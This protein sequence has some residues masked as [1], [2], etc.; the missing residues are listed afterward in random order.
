MLAVLMLSFVFIVGSIAAVANAA[1]LPPDGAAIMQPLGPSASGA[2]RIS[3]VYG[4][5]GNSG[6]TYKRDFIEL[7]NVGTTSVDVTGW[8]VQ[9]ASAASG[10]WTSTALTGTIAPGQY[11]LVAERYGAGGSVDLT[12]DISGSI[13]MATTD[14]KVA[15]ANNGVTLSGTCPSSAN[16]QDFIGYGG[17]VTCTETSPAPAPSNTNADIR[18][19]NGCQD[20]DNNSLDF[21][22]LTA[23][24]RNTSSPINI[25]GLSISKSAVASIPVNKIFTYTLV[26][27]NATITATDV[28][29]TDLIPSNATYLPNSA[30]SAG[31]LI[32]GTTISWTI[33]SIVHASIVSRTFVVTAPLASGEVVNDQYRVSASNI[34]SAAIGSAITTSVLPASPHLTFSKSVT[35]NLNVANNSA[36]TYT[37]ILTNDEAA[38]ANGVLM[39]DT[40]PGALTFAD[41]IISP[42]NTAVS[43]QLITWTGTISAYSVIS[44]NFSAIVSGTGQTV[45]NSA[46]IDYQSN[47]TSASASLT[48]QPAANVLINELDAQ[49]TGTDAA[50]FVELYD[51]G[52][53]QTG[54]DGLVLVFF[55]GNAANDPSYYSIDLDNQQTD[56]NGYFVVGNSAIASAVITF[57]DGKLQN[58]FDAVG[59]FS[60]N[61]SDFSSTPATSTSLIDAIVYSDYPT[62][63]DDAVLRATLLN[64]NEPIVYE[65]NTLALADIRSAQRCPNSSGGFRNT[66]AYQSSAPTAGTAN[67]CPAL[68]IAKDVTPTNNVAYH[69]NV[70]YTLV[71]SNSGAGDAFSTQLTDTLPGEVDFG[72]WIDRFGA[73][74]NSDVITWTGEVTAH[75]SIAFTFSVTHVGSYSDVVTNTAQFAHNTDSGS[76]SSTFSVVPPSPRLS[77]SKNA[78]PNS[79]VSVHGHVTYTLII[80]NDGSADALNTFITDTLPS[81][82]AFDHWID[83]SSAVI[84]ADRITWNG[85]ISIGQ[86]I[87]FTFVVSHVGTYGDVVTNTAQFDQAAGSGSSDAVFNVVSATPNLALTKF[88]SPS[89]NVAYHGNVT[90]TLLI[91]NSGA[92]DASQTFITDALPSGVTF[93]RWI[94]QAGANESANVITWNGTVTAANTLQFSFVV[95]HTGAYGESITNTAQFA[96]SSGAGSSDAAFSIEPLYPIVFVYHDGEDVV[97]SGEPVSISIDFNGMTALTADVGYTLFSNTINLPAGAHSYRYVAIDQPDWLNTLTR[98]ITV[99]NAATIDDYRNVIVDAAKLQAPS[100]TTTTIGV[101]TE[102]IFGRLHILN[103]TE[104]TGAGR[105]LKAQLGYGPDTS[106]SNWIWSSINFASQAGNDDQFASTITPNATGLYSVAVRFDPNWG[107]DNPNAGWTYGDLNDLPFTIDQAGVLH[108][109]NGP[110]LSI[111]KQVTP[112]LRVPRGGVVTY[113][114]VL[115]NNGDLIANSVSFTDALPAPADF[116]AWIISPTN[117]IQASDIITWSGDIQS[118]QTITFA[119]TSIVTGAY[120]ASVTNTASIAYNNSLT[121]GSAAFTF[122]AASIIINEIDSDNVSTDKAEFIEL[123][124][125]GV[126]NTSL[127]GLVVVLFS[128]TGSKVSAPTFDLDSYSTNSNGYFLIGGN[129]ISLTADLSFT[130]PS[131]LLNVPSAVALFVGSASDFPANKTIT[132]TD[133]SLVMDAIVYNNSNGTATGLLPLLNAGQSQVNENG[134][135]NG[136][137]QSLQRCLNGSGGLRNTSTVYPS[138]PT[139]G[140]A[141]ACPSLS[142]SKSVTP[143]NQVAYHGNVTTTLLLSNSGAGDALTAQLTDTLPAE[144]DFARWITRSG[145]NAAGDVIT[146]TGEVTASQSITFTFVVTHVGTFND[147]V[148]NTGQFTHSTGSGS[149]NATFTVAPP[150]PHLSLIKRVSPTSNVNYRGNVTYTIVLSNDGSA[151]A[152]NTFLTDT[153][154]SEVDFAQWLNQSGANVASDVITWTGTIS[155]GQAITFTFVVT[156]VGNYG[157]VVTNTA[158]FDQANGSGSGG[159]TFN[160]GVPALHMSKQANPNTNVAYHGNVT[161]T[162]VLSNDGSAAAFDTFLTDTLPSEVDFAHWISQAGA[163]LNADQITWHGTLSAGQSITFTFVVTHVGDYGDVV[164]NT[165][166]FTHNTGSGSSSA[167]FSVLTATPNLQLSKSVSPNNGV[168]YHGEVTYTISITNSGAA[169]AA[170]TFITDAL[171]SGVTFARWINQATATETANVIAW[172][173]AVSSA[174]S[175]ALTFVVT[176]TGSYG[177]VITNVAQF[178]HSSGAGSASAT[179]SVV[180]AT[181][182]LVFSKNVTPNSNVANQSTVTYTLVLMNDGSAMAN[183]VLLTDSLPSALTFGGWIVS[184]TN[185][186]LSGQLIT[187]SGNIAAGNVISWNFTAI[188]SGTGLTVNNIAQ[189]NHQ[190][191]VTSASASLTVQPSVNILINEIDADTP[192]TDAAEFIELYDGGVGHTALDGLVLVL[193]NGSGNDVYLPTFDLDGYATDANGYFVIGNAAITSAA[194]VFADNKL[195]NGPEAAALFVGSASDFPAGKTITATDLSQ[196]ID[197]IVYRN[198]S[199]TAPNLQVLLNANEPQPNENGRSNAANQSLQ[200]CPNGSGGY[201][202]TVTYYPSVPTAGAANA[203]PSLSISKSVN[204]TSNVAY[205][206]NVTYTIVVSNNGSADA[207]NT[208]VTDTLPSQVDFAHWI[209]Q[210]SATVNADKIT[211]N[212]TLSIGQAITLT[213]VV[214]HVGSYGDVVTNTAQFDHASGSGSSN[215]IF[216]VLTATPNLQLTKSASPGSNVAY[217]GEVTYTVLITNSGALD[218]VSIFITDVLPSGVTFA[219]WLD[220]AGAN[221]N[222]NVITWTGT[223]SSAQSI[224]LMFVVTHTGLYGD[225]ITNTAQFDHSSGTGSA[226]ATFTVVQAAPHLVFS[227]NVNPNSNVANH[228][229][230]TY[231]LMLTNDGSA[232]ANGVL[233]TDSLPSA[234]TFGSWIVSPTNTA[235]NGQALIWSGNVLTG[236]VLVWNFTAV[237]SGTGLTVNNLAQINYQSI[238]TAASASLVVLPSVNVLINELDGQQAG[239]PDLAEFIELYDGGTGHTPLDGLALVFFNGGVTNDPAY[240]AIDLD[241]QQTDANGYFVVGNAAIASATI[242]FADGKLQNGPDAVGLYVGNASDF[243]STPATNT[244][245]IDAIVYSD[246]ASTGDDAVLRSTL[247][248]V[249]QPL[250]VEGSNASQADIRSAQRCL[251][252]SGGYRNT[253][254]YQSSVPTPGRVNAC[255]SLSIT[256]RVTPTNNVAYHG[257][258]TYTLVLSNSGAGDALTAQLTDTLPGETDFAKWITRSGA[259]AA[260]DVITWT[261]LVTANQSITFT[262]VVTY[263]GA[264]GDVVTN[265]AQFAHD[266]GSGSSVATFRVIP[267]T[268]NL[269]IHKSVSPANNVAY[270][271]PVT[272]TLVLSNNGTGDASNVLITDTLPGQVDFAKWINQA[273]ASMNL[274][275]LTWS[276]AISIGQAITFTFVVTHVGNYGDVVTNTAQFDHASGSGS[277]NAIFTVLTA[278]PNLQLTKSASPGSNVAYHGEVTYTVL[279]TNS[280]ALDAVSIFITD[281]LPS[282]VTFARWLDQAGANENAN[283]ITWTG[284]VSSAQSIALMFVVTHTGL[285]GDVI[286]NTAQFDHS[287]GTGSASATFTVVPA[288]PHLIFSKSV[289]PNSDVANHSTV[290]YTLVLTNDGSAAANGVLMTDT[291]PSALT[292]GSWIVSPTNSALNS[293]VIS[294]NG[295]VLTGSVFAWN[296]TA[297]VSG[298]GLMV[299][300]VAQINY[301]SI[302]TATSA[303][304]TVQPSVNV[305]INE[306][307]AQTSGTD[308]QE[309]IELYDG[310]TGHTPLDGLALVLFNGGAVNDPS[311]YAIDLDN[312]Q[313]DAN[314]YFVVGNTAIASAAITFTDGKLQN[315]PDAVGLFVG[316]ASDFSSTPATST[317]LIDAIVYA[318]YPTTGD[319]AALRQTLL[320]VN[321]PM[322]YEGSNLSQ[323]EI[324]SAQRCL[325]GSGGYRNTSTYQSSVPTPGA[326][327]ACPSLSISKSV[328]PTSNVANHGIVTYTIALNNNGSGDAFSAQ[329]TDTLP[330]EVDFARWI[331]KSGANAASDVITWTGLVTA[332]QSI[333]FTFVVTH[334]GSY[335]DVVTNTA[336]FTHNTGS[337]SSAA[338]FSVILPTPNLHLSKSVSPASNVT[339]HGVVTYTLVVSN[340]GT[341]DA[342]NV[343]LTDTLPSQVDFARWINSSGANVSADQITWNGAISIGQSITLTFVVTH[344]G[345]YGDVVTNTAQFDHSSRS[346]SSNATFSVTPALPL[347]SIAKSVAAIHAPVKLGDPIT[348]TIMVTNSGPGNAIAV[349]ISDVLPTGVSGANL[350]QTINISASQRVSFTI[351]A[352]V[353]NNV[354]YYGKSITNTVAFSHSSGSGSASVAFTIEPIP[355]ANVSAIKFSMPNNQRVLPN[356][357]VTYTI[358]LSN[359]GGVSA[360]VRIT[361][362]IGPYFTVFNAL[363]FTQSPTGTLKWTGVV[364]AGRSITLSFVVRVKAISQLPIG[365]SLLNNAAT[366]NDGVSVPYVLNALNPPWVDV[367][368]I[369]LPLVRKSP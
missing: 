285:Y 333:T 283:V 296:F 253:V 311:Y 87:T 50:E 192:G 351:A 224:A 28:V 327:N 145:A 96:H 8:S 97:H 288:T 112:T 317:N 282:G 267:P 83:Q 81:E 236:S 114:I 278:T 307:D 339:Y 12:H 148:T 61:A 7:F 220:Q 103:V 178:A 27:T 104:P 152:L 127:N 65:A 122:D 136:P 193:F 297:V 314:G 141:N 355:P 330:A 203:C 46:Q 338:T 272:Y 216:T 138:T 111:G 168:A 64:A 229:T 62:T 6:A 304:L 249:N 41:W 132:N 69:G 294:W 161:Y 343:L 323:A 31:E 240:Y 134:R 302:V 91:T 167:T 316:N 332:N 197:A 30:S 204:Q 154:P 318:D 116:G 105:G 349:V 5:G 129:D 359:S 57:I 364:T 254:T 356:S 176:H 118:G 58:G 187:W 45:I 39:T 251:N 67:A 82:V 131:W 115:T 265:T 266:T 347:L 158:Q 2:I 218:A 151:G 109:F 71:L 10:S 126:G 95:T 89:T 149:A 270:H 99:A 336:Q 337:G 20:L 165:A 135:G 156:H 53:G 147:V 92:L 287:S 345:S 363:N 120:A 248:N 18:K 142:I 225:V 188:V 361:D 334:V 275:R 264:Y 38:A 1:S 66:S 137:T 357:L 179:F 56:A 42:T 196:E 11:F 173:G 189:I 301:Q 273:G 309:F 213:F 37:L 133:L 239:N 77:M 306:L 47:F 217:H 75:Q 280:G 261:G 94:D 74:A 305:L 130:S 211:W 184:P 365:H 247:L 274:D 121:S 350:N 234:L 88:A 24:P 84:N 90:Y 59:L 215:A 292:F 25:C 299:N 321:Q 366:I 362:M 72:Y 155:I 166:Q 73:N 308:T 101:A 241:N 17:T 23:N 153:L 232:A 80:S 110:S 63:G 4:G 237:V 68:S 238:V 276:G 223:V 210:S 22:A 360:T 194:I 263:V 231:T 326:A 281:A 35:P 190:S 60:G 128:G 117:T 300:N 230:V 198:S 235:L 242:T 328:T 291:L 174:Q 271:A 358:V 289:N 205:H 335:G 290:T 298:T 199:T 169:D 325:N 15:L 146:W 313:T 212:G 186:A 200:R 185:T 34:T 354:V 123:Y 312:Q 125:G 78:S 244:N 106:P 341:G 295:N 219:R 160:V 36:V 228:S 279:I 163:A 243:S 162:I 107:A 344:V 164:T 201:R 293:N 252:G 177:D 85:A 245:L 175:I 79:N 246:I 353:T 342:S 98:S 369:Y 268:P 256:K 159:A 346:G 324:K 258:V 348:Y 195:Q 86:S 44:W 139:A 108:A 3:Q 52:T 329:L 315:G 124:D 93:A 119:F 259:N 250:V 33:A 180:P 277:S 102:N 113:T 157:D 54:L 16:I 367:F 182:H 208:F 140:A 209:N 70:T 55:N 144:V 13:A 202:N 255:P 172:N 19:L 286:T 207:T 233:L 221:E 284:T 26:I 226:S 331:N 322:A 181:P 76:A 51:G 40:L 183:G 310:G 143:T 29:I 150:S 227:K 269:H 319:D 14:A 368:G 206:G 100:V 303:A 222:A 48:V 43:G 191:I 171:P 260:S 352:V 32:D 262:L 170:T 340:N 320:N 49:N 21:S 257:T 9:Y 214:T